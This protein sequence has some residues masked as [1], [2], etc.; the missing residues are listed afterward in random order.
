MAFITFEGIDGSGKSTVAKMLAEE[1]E[2]SGKHVFFT[3]EPTENWIGQQIRASDKKEVPMVVEAL[4]F[5]ADRDLHT[6]EIEA[7]LGKGEF[8]ICDRYRD[9]SLAYQ[10]PKLADSIGLDNALEWI[11]EI[12]WPASMDP[13]LTFLFKIEPGILKLACWKGSVS[14]RTRSGSRAVTPIKA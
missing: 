8:V 14:S 5:A 1:L 7:H 9:S 2:K 11:F 13:D 12:N 10:G 6:S 3:C 4:L